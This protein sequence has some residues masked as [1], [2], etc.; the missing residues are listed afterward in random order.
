[1]ENSASA[2]TVVPMDVRIPKL[3]IPTRSS[4]NYVAK[5]LKIEVTSWEQGNAFPAGHCLEILGDIGDLETEIRALLIE[6]Q[7][8]LEPFSAQARSCLPSE[9]P[10]WRV[11]ELE[12][13]RRKDLRTSRR[14]FSVDPPGCQDIDDTMHA[15]ILPNG[16]VEGTCFLDLHF[17]FTQ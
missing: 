15:E 9:G 5:R 11:P 1:M 13:Q 6:N 16:D 17:F 3:R 8:E 12:I 10:S 4:R 14:I 2:V 7:V